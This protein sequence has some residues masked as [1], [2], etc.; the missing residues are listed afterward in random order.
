MTTTP[1]TVVGPFGNVRVG[2]SRYINAS[3]G[4][5]FVQIN[6]RWL[7]IG[8]VNFEDNESLYIPVN[9]NFEIRSKKVASFIGCI[10]TIKSARG[11]VGL[12]SMPE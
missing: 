9:W 7:R 10:L 12:P 6:G 2:I 1:V 11:L 3:E 4:D 5:D 8:T